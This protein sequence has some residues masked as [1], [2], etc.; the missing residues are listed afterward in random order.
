MVRQPQINAQNRPP[1]STERII[2]AALHIIDGQGLGRLTMRRL[3]DALEVEAMAIYHHLPRG[4]EQLLDGLVAH[5]GAAPAD[6]PGALERAAGW[7]DALR[8]WAH[9]YRARLLEHAGVLPLLVTGRNPAA[10]AETTASLREILRQGGLPEVPAAAAAHALLAFVLGHAALEVR[11]TAEG[12]AALRATE[13]PVDWN[14][15][16]SAGLD[17]VL[18]AV[19]PG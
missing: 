2:E 9:D 7:R 16:F 5:V 1:L 12:A 3:G 8:R 11:G 14:T 15:R 19:N 10:L 18:N 13:G 4:K 17:L 6:L